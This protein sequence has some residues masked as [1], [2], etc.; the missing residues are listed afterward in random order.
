M[1]Q[2]IDGILTKKVVENE[3]VSSSFKHDAWMNYN[4][5]DQQDRPQNGK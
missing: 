3:L 1:K 4:W 2:T 5:I